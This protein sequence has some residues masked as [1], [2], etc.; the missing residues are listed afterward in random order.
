MESLDEH[1]IRARLQAPGRRLLAVAGALLVLLV[2][3][4]I[5]R[6]DPKASAEVVIADPSVWFET[7]SAG[8][9]VEINTSSLDVESTVRVGDPGQLLSTHAGSMKVAIANHET[10]TLSLV[11]RATHQITHVMDLGTA[12]GN[13]QL[14]GV[15]ETVVVVGEARVDRVDLE[16]FEHTVVGFTGGIAHSTLGPDATVYAIDGDTQAVHTMAPDAEDFERII[17]LPLDTESVALTHDSRSVLLIDQDRLL[18]NPI[19]GDVQ[20]VQHKESEGH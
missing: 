3:V 16:T 2:L 17:E 6:F 11:D 12:P 19:D 10:R 20:T 1:P 14:H 8:A 15:G 4:G 13:I 9:I 7:S 18:V 5:F